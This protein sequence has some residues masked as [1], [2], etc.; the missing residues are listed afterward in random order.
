MPENNSVYDT[1]VEVQVSYITEQSDPDENRYVFSYTVT[2]ENHGEIPAKLLS[3]HWT[4]TDAD[5]NVQEV[6]GDG[7]VGEQPHLSPGDGFKYTSG[8]ILKTPIGSM[9][10]TYH[11]IADDGTE[12]DTPIAPFSLSAPNTLH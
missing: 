7:V 2:I 9:R 6:K 5:G 11:M 10:G 8:T 1:R 4:I 3:R 12:F